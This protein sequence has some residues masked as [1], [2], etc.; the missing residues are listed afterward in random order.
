MSA[1][2]AKRRDWTLGGLDRG[3]LWLLLWDPQGCRWAVQPVT[4]LGENAAGDQLLALDDASQTGPADV[5]PS[6]GPP[7][8]GRL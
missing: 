4:F 6:P 8:E 2:R 3:R 7:G 1:P 5:H